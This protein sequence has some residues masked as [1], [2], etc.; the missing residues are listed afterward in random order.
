MSETSKRPGAR[1]ISEL[2]AR[3]GLKKGGTPANKPAGQGGIVPPPGAKLGGGVIPAPPGAVPPQAQMPDASRDPFG[4]MNAMAQTAT[5]TPDFVVVNDGQPVES[6][7]RQTS[8]ARYGKVALMLLAPLLVGTIVGKI[9][10]GANTYNSVIDDAAEIRDDVK[11]VGKQLIGLQQ[12]LQAAKERGAG[13]NAFLS[14]DEKLTEELEGLGSIQG[15]EALVYESNLYTLSPAV[16]AEVLGFYSDVTRLN[17]MVEEHVKTSKEEAKIIKEG[18]VRLK[19]FNPYQFAGLID[20][21]SGE[22]AAAGKPVSI[23]MV[24]L[25]T[26][27][28]DGGRPSASGCDG[29][30]SGFQYRL[31]QQGPWGQK[32]VTTA[33]G[34]K[35]DG[36]ALIMIDPGTKVLQ[37]VVT[38]GQSSVA[39]AA[40]MRR[41][42]KLEETVNVLVE[43]RKII[44]E[45]M[46]KKA[47]EGKKFTFF[48]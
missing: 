6:V 47:N 40:Y 42:E 10:A 24:Q 44:E 13:G 31:D 46:H 35:V 8:A 19:G 23:K 16:V 45:A 1:D 34:D 9:S 36:N 30:P 28:C 48:M 29:M 15:D 18:Q 5:A 11:N 25:G 20:I 3:L 39:E 43:R 26:P 21:P 27:I 12:T 22:D 32:S 7:D 37:Q 41:I 4:A 14:N 17:Q 33:S 38:G 2:K